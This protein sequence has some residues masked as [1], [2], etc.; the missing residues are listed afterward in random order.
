MLEKEKEKEKNNIKLDEIKIN[1]IEPD[2]E[3]EIEKIIQIVHKMEEDI[4]NQIIEKIV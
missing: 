3:F 1:D 2:K 4:I